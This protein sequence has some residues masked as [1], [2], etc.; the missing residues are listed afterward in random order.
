MR[1]VYRSMAI[2]LAA[3]SLSGRASAA[4]VETVLYRFSGI[5]GIAPYAG[6]IADMQG[7]LYGTT[8]GSGRG[9][10]TI[11][12]LTPP[13]TGQTAWTETV[14]CI[15]CSQPRCSDGGTPLLA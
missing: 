5:D 10:G 13:G 7:A 9:K 12:K 3:L 15:F 1:I 11:F 14:L 2:T 4:P 6:L 8:P